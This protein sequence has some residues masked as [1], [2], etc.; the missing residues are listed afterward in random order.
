MATQW[1]YNNLID[2]FGSES[3]VFDIDTIPLGADFREYLNKEVRNCDILLAV[4]GDQWLEI[5]KKRLDQPNDFV[6]IEIQAALERDIPV[7]PILV[8]RESVPSEKDLPPELAKLSYKQAT[9]VRAG[10]DVKSHLKRLVDGLNHLF[11]EHKVGE[12]LKQK[13]VDED[14]KHEES[15][16]KYINSIGMEFVLIQAGNFMM[17]SEPMMQAFKDGSEVNMYDKEYPRHKV[18]ISNEFY[19][20]STVVTQGQWKEVTAFNPSGFYDCGDDCPV[21]KVSWKDAQKFIEMLNEVEKGDKYRL[22]TE[23]E[24]EYACRAGTNTEFSFGDDAIKLSEYAWY[25][26]NSENRMHLAGTKKTN[27]WDLYDMHGNVLEWVEDD[28]HDNYNGAPDEGRPWIDKPRGT[29]RVI[30]GGSWSDYELDCRSAARDLITPDDRRD[31]VGF[32]LARSV[33]LGT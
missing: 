1:I 18:T 24:W 31:D 28:R 9:E 10:A 11:P 3:V 8:G 22:P 19:L 32:R 12:K 15:P 14:L 25:E 6:R 20:Q 26:D 30:R 21:E 4:I 27:P 17:G 5:L 33:T 29:Y 13:Q 7:V 2:H 16:K 23:A